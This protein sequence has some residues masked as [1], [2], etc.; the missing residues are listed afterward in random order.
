MM[1]Q[2]LKTLLSSLF[3]LCAM[4]SSLLAD[5]ADAKSE[6]E[7][8][9]TLKV[10]PLLKEKCLGCHGGNANDIKGAYSILSREAL[11]K[12]GESEEIAVVPG[13]PEQGTLIEAIR[14]ESYE[15]PPK[16]NDRLTEEQIA[17]VAT[18]IQA[19]APWPSEQQQQL[20][21]EESLTDKITADG[22]LMT[23]SGGLSEDWTNRRYQPEDLWAY[24]PFLPW[25]QL[26]PNQL[27]TSQLID[28][29]VYHKLS[30]QKLKA[31]HTASPS[32]LIRRAS[33]DLTGLPPTLQR[34]QQFVEDW[35]KNPEQTW[36]NYIEELLSSKA[37]G[38]HWARH[39]L[40]VVRYSD[41]GGMAN[42]YER[43]NMWRYR[44]YVIRSLNEDKPYNQFVIEQL[45]G[46][47]LADQSVAK[48][49]GTQNQVHP[50]QL[51]GDYTP[52]EAEWIVATGFLRMGPWD[53]AMIE[54]PE[55]RQI[56][57]DDLVNITG[58]TFLSTTM[59]CVKCHDHKFDPI[60]T[61]DYYRLYAA[62]S[63]THMAERSVP[64]LEE[65][66][67]AR[68]DQGKAHVKR[69]LDFATAERDRLISKRET[70]AKAWFAE[71]NLEYKNNSKRRN[72]PDEEKP[73]RAIGLSVT[74]QGQL[75][76][77]EQD[78]WIWNRRLERYQPMA[79]SVYNAE[80]FELAWNG[81]RKLRIKRPKKQVEL[82][83]NHIFL[84]GALTAKGEI[85][86]PGV[87][88]LLGVPVTTTLK[89]KDPYLI[90]DQMEYRRLEL[91]RWIANEQNTLAIRSIVNRV[92][93]YHFG[94]GLAVNSNN[95]GA[96][97]AKPTH[98]QLLDALCRSFVNN[99]W[100]LKSLHRQI[101]RSKVY[102]SS[103]SPVDSDHLD[104]TDPNNE[105]LSFFPR[106]RLTAE[107][108]RDSLLFVT[109]ELQT[110]RGGLPMMPEINLEVALQPRMIQF[111]LAP[112]YQPSTTPE[113]RNCRSVYA[114]QV[115]GQADPFTELFNQPNSN[116]SCEIRE[117]A[118]VTPQA[119]TML[120]SDLMTDRSIAFA[121]RLQNEKKQTAEQ[122]QR[123]FALAFGRKAEQDEQ[124][125]MLNYY[126]EMTEYHQSVTP[127]ATVYPTE[128]T[129]SLVEEF[130]GDVFEYQEILPAFEHYTA[131]AKPADVSAETRALADV[132]LL[133]MNTNEFL[134]VE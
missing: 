128:I 79:Q 119:F 13:K 41:T 113:Q 3:L 101:M 110:S 25:E 65:E 36:S 97:G 33:Y 71:R 22:M 19:G 103:T 9:F 44:D 100:S 37:Y 58:Q 45:A 31:S 21:R 56:Y 43:S 32:A 54:K 6:A 12:G 81:A 55:A 40:D 24:Q 122:I 92:W 123:A 124:Q 78:V 120:N 125:L 2:I 121:L 114:Y 91:A 129:R 104:A 116:D 126:N 105:L 95:F 106:R 46:D 51:S 57:L 42:D 1:T 93:Q 16:Q 109:G 117:A 107:E 96:T 84:G 34:I 77:R 17:A 27:P 38:E 72:L 7:R 64:F 111:S 127:E 112:A 102:R 23:T 11:L 94:K 115:R 59:R 50:T 68:F 61:R 88:S 90:T 35:E 108:L 53:N 69:L 130:S 80:S 70:A 134:Y 99:G 76:V 30:Q 74:E 118:A 73:P 28:Q 47:E 52:Q 49:K 75:K 133:L 89:T 26:N 63:T 98:P 85:V 82:P 15:M 5:S 18:W 20:Y 62:F 132:C 67:Q 8:H 29:F 14:W 10:L 66:S 48:R 131:D 87:L 4:Q 60:P 83:T 86:K 39:W